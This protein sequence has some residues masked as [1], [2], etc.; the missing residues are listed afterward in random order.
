MYTTLYFRVYDWE[1]GSF[2]NTVVRI[3][4]ND[5]IGM[6]QTASCLIYTVFVFRVVDR[7]LP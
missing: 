6:I 3:E 7:D 1:T 2:S 5:L 4:M